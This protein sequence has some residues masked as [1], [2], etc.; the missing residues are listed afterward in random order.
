MKTW[1]SHKTPKG[2]HPVYT[3]RHLL[4]EY[5]W[6]NKDYAGYIPFQQKDLAKTFR[7][8]FEHMNRIFRE[9]VE[10]GALVKVRK[11]KYWVVDPK[12]LMWKDNDHSN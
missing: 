7:T 10:A 5:L 1:K 11:G 12:K 8:S 2:G 4:H 9:M 6:N 3:D